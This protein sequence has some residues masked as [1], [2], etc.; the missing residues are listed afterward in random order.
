MNEFFQKNKSI[1][2]FYQIAAKIIGWTLIVITPLAAIQGFYARTNQGSA[3][4]YELLRFTHA[5]I[6]FLFLGFILLGVAKF[7]KYL[8]SEESHQG[9]ILR[10]IDKL[11]YFY[12]VF[13]A[14]DISVTI[15]YAILVWGHWTLPEITGYML[16]QTLLTLTHVLVI[17]GLAQVLRRILP[18]IE[19]SKTLV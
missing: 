16:K 5:L 6:S 15:E 1:L 2:I 14:L 8:Y 18:V 9:W 3:G 13:I 12:A 7:I 11:L 10:N 4:T 19:E 17:V